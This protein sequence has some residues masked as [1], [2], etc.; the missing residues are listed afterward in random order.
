MINSVRVFISHDSQDAR[1]AHRL[2]DDLGG[3]GVPVWIA[4]ESIQPGESWVPAIE[5][6]LGECTHMVI[7]L[8]PAALDSQ[9]VRKETEVAITLERQGRMRVIPLDVEPCKVPLLLSSYQMIAL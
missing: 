2:A 7:V 5:R 1:F 9:W 4:P 8:T 6:G 3:L